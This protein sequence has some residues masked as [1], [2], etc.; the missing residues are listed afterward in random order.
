M[1]S[2]ADYMARAFFH[3]E[4]GRGRAAPNPLVGAVVV[5]PDGVAVGH[6][7]HERAGE[8]HAEIHALAAAGAR[9][10]GATLYCTLEPCAHVGRTPPCVHAIVG[11]GIARVVAPIEDPNPLVSGRGFAYLRDHGVRVEIGLGRVA[12]LAQNAPFFSVVQRRRPVVLAKIA[13][14]IDACIAGPDGHRVALTSE[15]ANRRVH[16]LRASVD[17]LAVGSGTLI[18]DDPALTARGAFRERPLVRVVFDRRLR[19]PPGARVFKTADAGPI[20][21]LT[22]SDAI[23]SAADRVRALES[24]GARVEPVATSSLTAMVERLVDHDVASVL[25]EG[26]AEVHRAAWREGLID[27]VHVIVTPRALGD[28]GIKWL[29]ADT[30]PWAATGPPR[31]TALG[32]DV[33]LEADVHRT[34]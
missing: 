1:L 5:S 26:G 24:A 31:A 28:R 22:T 18:A 25:L 10:G 4:R 15:A 3:A 33:W 21:I 17:A 29:D 6:G 16:L 7:Y 30:L 20:V 2:D 9:A 8:P 23:R 32:P 19:T 13:M 27:R 11:A 12:A 14:S 34:H